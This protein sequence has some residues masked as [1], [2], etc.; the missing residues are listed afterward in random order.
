MNIGYKHIKNM[1]NWQYFFVK[2]DLL[3]FELPA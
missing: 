2:G 1:G 3:S